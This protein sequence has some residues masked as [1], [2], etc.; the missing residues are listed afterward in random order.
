MLHCN[1][2]VM[3][4]LVDVIQERTIV[5]GSA[6]AEM[7]PMKSTVSIDKCIHVQELLNH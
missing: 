1:F 3:T 5:M 6:T 4:V 7:V 2:H